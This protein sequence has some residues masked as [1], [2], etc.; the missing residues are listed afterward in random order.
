[1]SA[2]A[3]IFDPTGRGPEAS[4]IESMLGALK[5]RSPAGDG[6]W[7]EGPVAL[8]HGVL[9]PS[10]DGCGQAPP[11]VEGELAVTADL[12]LDNRD[13][14]A[15]A[16]G[17]G[18]DTSDAGLV[19]AAYRRWGEACPEH[20][21][22]DFAFALWDSGRQR[23]LCARDHFGV[24]PF[25]YHSGPTSFAFASEIKALLGLP[26]VSDRFDEVGVA[27]FLIGL[28]SDHAST[29]YADVRRLP[30]AHLMTVTASERRIRPY[31]RLE[32]GD[33]PPPSDPAAQF[34]A[35]FATAVERR[36]RSPE[37]V[38]AMLSGGLDSSSIALVAA[39]LLERQ[40]R[41]PLPTLSVVFDETPTE[42]ERPFIEAVLAAGRFDPVFI[43]GDTFA[44]FEGF[45]RMLAEQD[46]LFIAPG[47][48]FSRRLLQAAARLDLPV[49]LDGHGGDEV[50][51]HG[52]GRL[53]ELL[54]ARR[55][56][57]LW[58]ET[59]AVANIYGEP[60][61]HMY[62][63][64]LET[65]GVGRR[66]GRVR[67][68]A[69]RAAKRIP[70]L[71]RRAAPAR[72]GLASFLNPDL[73]ART[74]L[75]E[76]FARA[77]SAPKDAKTEWERH[78]AV[79]NGPLQARALEVA[80]LNAAA[81]GVE[82]RYPFWDKDL[83]EFCLSLPSDQKLDGGWTRVGLRRGMQGVLPPMVQWRPDKFDFSGHLTR[84]ML[85]HHKPLLDQLILEDAEDIGG[86]VN[87]PA[88]RAAY[89]RVAEL[90]EAA[91]GYDVQAV[92]RAAAL[93]QW[94]RRRRNRA[95]AS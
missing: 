66:L 61:L 76:R 77:G 69:G 80:D 94:L 34:R 81:A 16:L 41:D 14:L 35:L 20:L 2:I 86:Y 63:T 11:L 82:V 12:R 72:P 42:S 85:A 51:S 13:A 83:V 15:S 58:R 49:L 46:G 56:R 43:E 95:I 27:E 32:I 28:V 5:H 22:G 93:G 50:V 52:F 91:M 8:G 90:A 40:G 70:V 55:W 36:M 92:W 1:M 73:V 68:A 47:L 7:R 88:V 4:S 48:A 31:W 19:L 78:L 71:R 44:P 74:D 17:H 33:T 62:L 65:V 3:G 39:E 9:H 87:L 79:L 59:K 54:A 6:V 89:G 38:G 18:P 23:L 30:P 25:Y 53:D 57:S 75:A 67:R 37:R 29:L 26:E 10:G 24:K 21:L 45:D 60:P 84:G 64:Q